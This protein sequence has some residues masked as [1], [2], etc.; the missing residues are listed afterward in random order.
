MEKS[1]ILKFTGYTIEKILLEKSEN[2]KNENGFNILYKIIPNN[3]KFEKNNVLMGV[4][5]K[6]SLD[7]PYNLEV[8]IRGNFVI[9]GKSTVD[10]KKKL[11]T[12]N[13]SAILFPYIRS[14][15]SLISSQ[16]DF[17]K[18]L[19]PTFNFM[20]ILEKIDEKDIFLEEKYFKDFQL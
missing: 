10:K 12:I 6:N 2:S 9:D 17:N 11:L 16:T 20:N 18:I 8:I 5:I 3:E 7:F 4:L 13:S 15:I 19:L 14:L 1:D